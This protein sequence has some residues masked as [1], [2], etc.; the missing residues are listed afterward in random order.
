MQTSENLARHYLKE[1]LPGKI[2]IRTDTDKEYGGYFKILYVNEGE[3]LVKGLD[4]DYLE[5]I[6]WIFNTYIS[7]EKLYVNLN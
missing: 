2:F 3:D 7:P 6:T 1:V 5:F 4:V